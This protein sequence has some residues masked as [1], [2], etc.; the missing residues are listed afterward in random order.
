MNLEAARHHAWT[1]L[2]AAPLRRALLGRERCDAIATA[3]AEEMQA[4]A[5]DLLACGGDAEAS[6]A[7]CERLRDRVER[8][9]AENCG[10]PFMTLLAVWAIS[11][12]VQALFIRWLNQ[13]EGR[14]P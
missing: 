10:M 3:T 2:A 8:R 1:S 13:Q 5:G 7:A 12:I 11:A 4:S 9:Y 14:A 6:A